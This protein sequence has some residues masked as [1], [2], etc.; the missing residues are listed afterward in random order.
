MDFFSA[1]N[2][3]AVS[4]RNAITPLCG[5]EEGG[6]VIGIG[7]D[8]TPTKYI[9][10]VAEDI[11]ISTL[12]E[13]GLCKTLISEE[14]GKISIGGEKGTIFLDPVDGT[15]NATM[16][17]PFYA[18]S[19][20]YA[21]EG[22]I[23]QAFVQNLATGEVFTAKKGGG[24]FLDGHLICV[25]QTSDLQTSAMSI[26][27]K[28]FQQDRIFNLMQKIRRFR[29]FGASALEISYVAAGRID[30][31]V[32]LRKTLRVTDAAAGVLICEEAGGIVTDL[33]GRSIS[34]ADEVTIG[35]CLI[36]TNGHLHRKVIEYLR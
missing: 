31:F 19:I 33:D 26:Y 25:S 24:A 30:G 7:A 13:Y 35:T 14:I 16:S 18:L 12:R 21:E 8:G 6:R 15:Y 10:K 4:V 36:A 29:Q 17:I 32:D 27:G 20:A 11:I 28:H 5:T 3:M 23:L 9:D 1:C 22:H 2:S 34:F